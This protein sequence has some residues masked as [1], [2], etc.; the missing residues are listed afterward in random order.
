MKYRD[1]TIIIM[2]VILIA[3]TKCQTVI[4]LLP[5]NPILNNC[6]HIDDQVFAAVILSMGCASSGLRKLIVEVCWRIEVRKGGIQNRDASG[7]ATDIRSGIALR[8]GGRLSSQQ[9]FCLDQDPFD[10][11]QVERQKAAKCMP[12]VMPQ[13]KASACGA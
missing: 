3:T 5:F 10:L 12:E 1:A 4:R 6:R 8:L 11:T 2:M 9:Q 7:A 13:A